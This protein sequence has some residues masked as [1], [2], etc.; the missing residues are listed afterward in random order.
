MT[1]GSIYGHLHQNVLR[2]VPV[3]L[4]ATTQFT[5]PET[6]VQTD[7]T[8]DGGLP[9]QVRILQQF[10]GREGDDA[11]TVNEC[12]AGLPELFPQRSVDI[13]VTRGTVRE[14]EFQVVQP[15]LSALH[16]RLV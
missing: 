15:A 10:A 5:I 1:S 11:L 8:A 16:E 9:L 13:I 3:E 14:T 4:N 2:G 6:E 7:I 12:R